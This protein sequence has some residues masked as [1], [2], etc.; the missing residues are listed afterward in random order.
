MMVFS[1]VTPPPRPFRWYV[2]PEFDRF[3]SIKS[4]AGASEVAGVTAPPLPTLMKVP[5][6]DETEPALVVVSSVK[7]RSLKFCPTLFTWVAV[8]VF[9]RSIVTVPAPVVTVTHAATVPQMYRWRQLE[10]RP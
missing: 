7:N 10:R 9:E 5:V 8:S 4:G 2:P 3:Q 1:G 6:E